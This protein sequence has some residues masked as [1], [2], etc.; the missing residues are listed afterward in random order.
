LLLVIEADIFHFK[1]EIVFEAAHVEALCIFCHWDVYSTS[2][3]SNVVRVQIRVLQ[4]NLVGQV[5]MFVVIVEV[6]LRIF[7]DVVE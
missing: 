6:P 2:N 5:V 1:G 7:L 3:I 4:K